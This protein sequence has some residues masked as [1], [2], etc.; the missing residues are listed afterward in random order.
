MPKRTKRTSKPKGKK[1]AGRGK[2]TDRRMSFRDR[3]KRSQNRHA[4]KGIFRVGLDDVNFWKCEEG[5]HIIDIIPYVAGSNNPDTE[6]GERDFK[7]AVFVHRDVG[8]VEGQMV[9]CP[10]E[11]FNQP[12]PICEHRKELRRDGDAD[13]DLIKELT[14]SR[15]SRVI[16]N[17]ICYDSR[18]EE[19]KG[20]Q[21]WHT[22]EYLF[23]QHLLKL[24]QGPVRR[25]SQAPDSFV[26]FACPVE[27]KSISFTTEG[28]KMNTKHMGM[29]F[30]DRDYEIDDET[31]D[32]AQCLD[33]LINFHTYDE[34]Y[35]LYWGEEGEGPDDTDD[36]E[37]DEP[38]RRSRSSRRRGGS[39]KRR[40]DE[41]EEYEEEDEDEDEDEYQEDE[42][43]DEED[44]CPAGGV[45][46]EDCNNYDD[47]EDCDRWDEC[48]DLTEGAEEEERDFKKRSKSKPKKKSKQKA[49]KRRPPAQGKPGKPKKGKKKTNLRRR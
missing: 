14:P 21:V 34:I 24:A 39:K 8:D 11:T 16:Y 37:E 6:E 44:D 27:G 41:D 48:Y 15:Y 47:C 33:E 36:E 12:C 23:D 5:Q 10:K 4:S 22:S 49:S 40:R 9:V 20:V 45:F 31:L 13:E 18:R 2:S 28:K 19:E 1:K 3:V 42:D 17:I 26:E 38:R 25:G 43:E 30:V 35:A 32:D 7:L 46:G 29:Q